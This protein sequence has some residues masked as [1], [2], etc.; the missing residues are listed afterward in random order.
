MPQHFGYS[1]VCK[2]VFISYFLQ[3]YR[4]VYDNSFLLNFQLELSSS[5]NSEQIQQTVHL[6]ELNNRTD[7]A[8][9]GIAQQGTIIVWQTNPLSTTH[10]H[11]LTHIHTHT[12]THTNTHTHTCFMF[13]GQ[14]DATIVNT[15]NSNKL[16]FNVRATS[17][18][19]CVQ[20]MIYKLHATV[21]TLK[22]IKDL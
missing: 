12:Q 11:T 6:H 22:F 7:Y 1:V 3:V 18:Y 4:H 5:A 17:V 19:M 16:I 15:N 8:V 21:H 14:S 2:R 9:E 13:T 10:T 20:R